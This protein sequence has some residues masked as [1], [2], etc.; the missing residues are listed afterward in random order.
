MFKGPRG[1]RRRLG[2]F[3]VWTGGVDLGSN[4]AN[5]GGGPPNTAK[6]GFGILGL[7]PQH[8]LLRLQ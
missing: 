4:P 6:V 7:L 5:A 3:L 1:R 8:I 2:G